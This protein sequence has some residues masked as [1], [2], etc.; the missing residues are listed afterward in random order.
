[1]KRYIV[2][3]SRFI[4][5]E[6]IHSVEYF[7]DEHS[8]I[9]RFSNIWAADINNKDVTWSGVFM[10]DVTNL[11]YIYKYEINDLRKERNTFFI[12]LR[13]F[14]KN[15]KMNH[16]VQYYFASYADPSIE[17]KKAVQ[18]W[19]NVIAADLADEQVTENG[20]VLFDSIGNVKESR[21]FS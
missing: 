21:Y 7:D 8:A 6:E 2:V 10:F 17:Y 1:M 9:Q 20:A 19:F 5:E 12:L 4:G 16:S 13:F 3:R 14:E 11:R 15:E 18:R